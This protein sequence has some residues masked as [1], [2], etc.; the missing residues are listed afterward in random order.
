MA[1]VII[2]LAVYVLLIGLFAFFEL[3]QQGEVSGAT[4]ILFTGAAIGTALFAL[5]LCE[6]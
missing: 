1:G 6:A 2:L 4:K 5:R 3:R